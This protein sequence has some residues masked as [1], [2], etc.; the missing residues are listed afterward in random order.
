MAGHPLWDSLGSSVPPG[1]LEPSTGQGANG[2]VT[3]AQRDLVD[4][5]TWGL[6]RCPPG[7]PGADWDRRAHSQAHRAQTQGGSLRTTCRAHTSVF[8]LGGV[9]R[10]SACCSTVLGLLAS[11]AQQHS[12]PDP[13]PCCWPAKWV[14]AGRVDLN[15]RQASLLPWDLSCSMGSGHS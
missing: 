2:E 11:C 9:A 14:S 13:T 15:L 5:H 12:P 6:L 4:L 8:G 7:G 1:A 10:L 3:W